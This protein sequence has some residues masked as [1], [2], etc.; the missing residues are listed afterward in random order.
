MAVIIG[1]KKQKNLLLKALKEK[2]LA[3]TWIFSG[4]SGIGKKTLALKIAS[5]LNCP[6]SEHACEECS[7]CQQMSLIQHE[8][9]LLISS[10]TQTIKVDS[11]KEALDFLNLKPAYGAKVVIVD[12]AEKMNNSSAHV[13][14]KVL[15]EPPS[16]AYFFLLTENTSRMLPTLLSRS[17]KLS[18][19]PLNTEE[20]RAFCDKK[21]PWMLR[22][23]QGRPGLLEELLE[24]KDLRK[25]SFQAWKDTF[26]TA[27]AL[28][29]LQTE[30]KTNVFFILSFWLE[31]VKDS[32]PFV[33]PI[34]EDLFKAFSYKPHFSETLL[35]FWSENLLQLEKD[36]KTSSDLH[37]ATENYFYQLRRFYEKSL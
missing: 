3:S 30:T 22:A 14:L 15:E 10:D 6:H 37:L 34:H 12:S 1:H 17:Q 26:K 32:W 18:F 4:L 31:F 8:N 9:L 27:Q 23:S 21:E 7:S 24:K 13:L 19:H 11:I 25:K 5:I 2:R 20:M 36:L 33:R 28:E 29:L 35:S 16:Y